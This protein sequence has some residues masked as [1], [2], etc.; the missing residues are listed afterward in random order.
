MGP[1]RI[2]CAGGIVVDARGRFLL[3]QRGNEPEKGRW[4]LPG[5]RVEHGES[6]A[7]AVVREVLEETGLAVQVDRLAGEVELSLGGDAVGAVQDF[8][9]TPARGADLDA[10]RAGDDA[11]DVGWF[12]AE[13]LRAL[14]TTS[15]LIDALVDWGVLP[16]V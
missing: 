11:T 16:A 2:A 12:T 6:A 3:I 4:T 10:V 13:E 7:E 1:R 5:G 14:P 8:V 9:C 15:A